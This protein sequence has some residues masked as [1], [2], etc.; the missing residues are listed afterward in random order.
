MSDKSRVPGSPNPGAGVRPIPTGRAPAGVPPLSLPTPATPIARVA[1]P[2][3]PAA[4]VIPETPLPSPP[5]S[6]PPS[7][8]TSVGRPADV[9]GTSKADGKPFSPGFADGGDPSDLAVSGRPADVHGTSK[10]SVALVAPASSVGEMAL[11]PALAGRPADVQLIAP[12]DASTAQH[13]GHAAQPSR[14]P[15]PKA[16]LDERGRYRHTLRLTPQNEQKLQE[17]AESLG[18]V[19]LSAAIAICITTYHQALA[20][21]SKSEGEAPGQPP[22][23]K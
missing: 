8:R 19:E 3:P 22:A 15:K 11:S 12:N 7:P 10:A 6:S 16:E 18:G 4:V 21:R 5:S 23:R 9:Q 20:K 14:R 13:I 2:P 17:I 1:Q